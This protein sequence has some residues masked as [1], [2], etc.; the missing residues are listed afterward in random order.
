MLMPIEKVSM[1][2]KIE[3]KRPQNAKGEP[4]KWGDPKSCRVDK[5]WSSSYLIYRWIR[6]SDRA[7]AYIGQTEKPLK[8][9]VNRY[10]NAKSHDAGM[11]WAN[12]VVYSEQKK[13]AR[14]KDWLFIEFCDDIPGFNLMEELSLAEMIL[15]RYYKPYLQF[16]KNLGS[17][18][19]TEIS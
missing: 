12:Y 1:K 8:F 6:E 19:W 11:G 17:G 3:W 16:S 18:K 15:I 10:H 5:S 2:F 14:K 7:V 13:L 9:R 4:F